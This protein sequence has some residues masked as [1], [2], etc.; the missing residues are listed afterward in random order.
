MASSSSEPFAKDSSSFALEAP[1]SPPVHNSH[2]RDLR[3]R[4]APA[5]VST[6]RPP[7]LLTRLLSLGML[8]VVTALLAIAGESAYLVA[9]DSF[10]APAILSPDSDVILTGKLK[11]GEFSVERSR[12]AAAM[13]GIDAEVAADDKGLAALEQLGGKLDQSVRFTSEVTSN[14]AASGTAEL[15][16]LLRQREII[17]AMVSQQK[18]LVSKAR[19]DLGA[20]VI[21]RSDYAKENQTLAQYELELAENDRTTL[22]R[23]SESQENRLAQRALRHPQDSPL[24]PDL[25]VREDQ[26]IHVQLEK[27]HLEAEKRSKLAERAALSERITTI[28]KLATQLRNRPV[29][30]AVDKRLEVAFVPYSQIDGVQAGARVYACVWALF[31]CKTV[32]TVSEIAPG[33]VTLPDPWGTPQ[34][35]QYA[36]LNLWDHEAAKLKM[37]RVRTG[38][39]PAS[40]PAPVVQK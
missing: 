16:A 9:R 35:G 38:D 10:V 11:L 14:K 30:Q 8:G 28:D 29:Y 24:T 26:K 23:D 18:E 12:V 1:T 34:R 3:P 4:V 6:T 31:F 21:S 17:S 27:A 7:A 2:I 40:A 39:Q 22:Q 5:N 20:G 33:E 32:G 13:E 15:E 25:M 36:V 37:L 19:A